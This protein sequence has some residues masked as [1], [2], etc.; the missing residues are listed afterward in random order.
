MKEALKY[1][2]G[3]VSLRM[4]AYVLTEYWGVE[5]DRHIFPATS[6][7]YTTVP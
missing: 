5:W 4:T 1:S 3:H 2:T 6:S 7:R